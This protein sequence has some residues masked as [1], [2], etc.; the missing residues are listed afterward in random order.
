MKI[1]EIIPQLSSGG[2]ERFVV[3]L[4]NE[5][6]N[7]GHEVILVVLHE[8]EGHGFYT[9]EIDSRVRVM[10]MEKRMGVDWGLPFRIVR[11]IHHERPDV[12]HTHLRAVVYCSLAMLPGVVHGVIFYHTVHTAA[13]QEAGGGVSAKIRRLIFMHKLCIPVTISEESLRSFE[14]FYGHSA[15]M[16][17]NGRNV[18]QNFQTSLAV[19]EEFAQYRRT[20]H[21]LILLCLA[22]IDKVKRQTMLARVA[23]R[24]EDEKKD[25]TL[26]LIGSTKYKELVDEILA[27]HCQCIHILGEKKN[28]LEYL[29]MSDAY[30]LPSSYE[31]LPISLIE[32]LGVGAVPICTPV[33]GILDI[34]NDG[35]NG[36]LTKDLSEESLYETL[37]NFLEM[38]NSEIKKLKANAHASYAQYSMTSCAN[39]YIELFNSS[40]S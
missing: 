1:I 31:G 16:I 25:F 5:M 39:K 10:S 18:P 14:D 12:V 35:E 15:P 22:R 30:C 6:V 13:R 2:G 17:P 24:L 37:R 29:K 34:I 32:A 20:Q 28:P 27:Y 7:T 3:D 26:L 33:G 38:S 21:T 19:Q 11:L 23:K 9:E 36:L 4:C 8:L 40:Q